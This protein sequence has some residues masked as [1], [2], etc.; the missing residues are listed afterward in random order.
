MKIQFKNILYILISISIITSCKSD[1][2]KLLEKLFDLEL[3]FKYNSVKKNNALITIDSLK[4]NIIVNPI[5]FT[6]YLNLND[7]NEISE[8]DFKKIITNYSNNIL[9]EIKYTED[10]KLMF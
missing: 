1:E 2:D 10:Y 3:S 7:E 6:T 8:L 5:E 9:K 4:T